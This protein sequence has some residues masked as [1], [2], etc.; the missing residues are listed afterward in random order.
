MKGAKESRIPIP[1]SK[2][3]DK[4][5][6]AKNL[7]LTRTKH[8]PEQPQ[9][10]KQLTG[11]TGTTK[12][13]TA[14][15]ST[16]KDIGRAISDFLGTEFPKPMDVKKPDFW[17]IWDAC[18]AKFPP[19]FQFPHDEKGLKDVFDLIGYP[20]NFNPSDFNRI[21]DKSRFQYIFGPFK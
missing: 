14:S 13:T 17:M 3:G 21:G 2:M 6:T 18:F 4:G 11:A 8:V 12:A 15:I 19:G 10:T 5:I 1:M 16:N 9:P 7:G 20:N